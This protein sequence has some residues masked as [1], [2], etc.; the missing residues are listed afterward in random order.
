MEILVTGATG[1]NGVELLK[2][3]SA[4]NVPARAMVRSHD[5]ASGI[6]GLPGIDIVSGDF[7]DPTSLERAL[8]GTKRAFLLTNSSERA[9]AQQVSFVAVARHS[10]V[11]HVVKLS[12]LAADE[13]SPV[14]FLRYH[15]VVERAIRES[16]LAYTFL[17]PNLFMQGLLG[18]APVIKSRACFYAAIGDA[19]VSVVDVRDVAAAAAAALTGEGHSGRTY[20]LT[21]PESLSHAEMAEHLSHATGRTITFVDVPAEAMREALSAMNMP[22]W[23]ADGLIEDYAHYRRGEA[24]VVSTGVRDATGMPPRSFTAFARD[25]AAQLS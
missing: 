17:R 24:A 11:E 12:Q 9:E 1:S 20:T 6:V 5:K 14:R 16:E 3:L 23:Q 10:S 25:Y 4:R 8:C 22:P 19:K 13:D 7:D 2:L 21:G 18:F 15:A